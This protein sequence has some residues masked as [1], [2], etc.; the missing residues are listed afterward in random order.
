L[1]KRQP[2]QMSASL[3]QRAASTQRSPRQRANPRGKTRARRNRQQHITRERT[4]D[5][6]SLEDPSCAL[7]GV[8]EAV[9]QCDG[10]GDGHRS[11]C[12]A[13]RVPA[14][15]IHGGVRHGGHQS[16]GEGG[17][18]VSRGLRI[19]RAKPHATQRRKKRR[20]MRIQT[21]SRCGALP[22]RPP[23]PASVR[24]PPRLPSNVTDHPL[25][26]TNA[27][28]VRNPKV[29]SLWIVSRRDRLSPRCV[30]VTNLPWRCSASNRM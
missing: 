22:P 17:A 2:P 14:R 13:R 26:G 30:P 23:C 1:G 12:E 16:R 4:C 7:S 28:E 29:C 25:Q 27:S 3:A 18:D 21:G 9:R 11:S 24:T 15:E 20:R 19:D 8:G 5:G 6:V 10:A